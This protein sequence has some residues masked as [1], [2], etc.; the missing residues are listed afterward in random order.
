MEGPIAALRLRARYGCRVITD[1]MDAWPETLLQAL[2][3]PPR[4]SST[5]SMRGKWLMRLG[6]LA[7]WPYAHMLRRACSESDAVSAQSETFAAFAKA[8]G[9]HSA[10]HVCYLGGAVPADSANSAN[11]E[12]RTSNVEGR[13]K[14]SANVELG[15]RNVVGTSGHPSFTTA[16]KGII[17]ATDGANSEVSTNNQQ[18]RKL[19]LL[20]LG[21]FFIACP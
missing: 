16:P 19:R 11:V 6:R 17:K 20:Y 3:G 5:L 13:T 18:P 1:V 14:G 12:H 21:G 8:H 15:T 7:L 4:S 2:S 10:V 9:A